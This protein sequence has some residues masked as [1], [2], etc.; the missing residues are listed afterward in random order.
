MKSKTGISGGIFCPVTI[1]ANKWRLSPHIC[2]IVRK[3]VTRWQKFL[4]GFASCHIFSHHFDAFKFD[5]FVST[6]IKMMRRLETKLL[7]HFVTFWH[8]LSHLANGNLVVHSWSKI[9]KIKRSLFVGG[10]V[11]CW[12]RDR[13][14]F[15]LFFLLY[16]LCN[17]VMLSFF[18]SLYLSFFLSFFFSF[19]FSF[20]LS[21][22]L[23]FFHVPK[24]PFA[25][26]T[27]TK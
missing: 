10:F 21:F 3:H 9:A 12:Y 25:F 1:I 26:L 20:F 11:A 23:S 17:F 4:S 8:N 13:T 5:F 7:S 2:D 19:F 16:F 15:Y 6:N 14:V 24:C 18:L 22:F 27:T